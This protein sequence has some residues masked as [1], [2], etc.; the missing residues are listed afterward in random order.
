MRTIARE[1][2]CC[3][4]CPSRLLPRKALAPCEPITSSGTPDA[5]QNPSE[6]VDFAHVERVPAG[7]ALDNCHS[8]TALFSHALSVAAVC[9]AAVPSD[10]VLSR[11]QILGLMRKVNTWQLAHPIKVAADHLWERATWYTGVMD[12]WKCT[13]DRQFIDQALEWGRT[14]QWQ[15]GTEPGTADAANK[16][17]AHRRGWRSISSIRTGR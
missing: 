6:I 14:Y 7:L 2:P 13:G 16:L 9:L 12:A 17:F 1:S 11:R 15:V 10:S 8:P 3:F 4:V 5:F